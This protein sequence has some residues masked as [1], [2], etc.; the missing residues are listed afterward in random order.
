VR[1]ACGV[2]ALGGAE[3]GGA[4]AAG[5]TRQSLALAAEALLV[6]AFA[7]VL[8]CLDPDFSASADAAAALSALVP[9]AVAAAATAAALTGSGDRGSERSDSCAGLPPWLA[10]VPAAAAYPR[11]A[12]YA[13]FEAAREASWAATV[14]A[15]V[16]PAAVARRAGR[17]DGCGRWLIVENSGVGS[18]G[19]LAACFPLSLRV[20]TA[21]DGDAA[22][23]LLLLQPGLRGVVPVASSSRSRS[24][25]TTEGSEGSDDSSRSGDGALASEVQSRAARLGGL[26][27]SLFGDDALQAW[28]SL[29]AVDHG[30]SF[31]HDW[32]E[33]TAVAIPSS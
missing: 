10:W 15:A 16:N 22:K 11:S 33:V 9:A 6:H 17:L 27:R 19:A 23:E 25:S 14:V 8:A 32:V 28:T 30:M 7:H 31:L 2:G 5:S 1:L 20:W 13:S 21:L 12:M 4:V 29:A 24:S 18:G 26:A 3:R